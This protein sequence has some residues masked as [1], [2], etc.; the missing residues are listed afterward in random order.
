MNIIMFAIYRSKYRERKGIELTVMSEKAEYRFT[1]KS[2]M[3]KKTKL[4]L[5]KQSISFC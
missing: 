4:N 3:E 5:N 2:A 1:N